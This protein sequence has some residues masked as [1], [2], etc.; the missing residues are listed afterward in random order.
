MPATRKFHP[1]S[2]TT[3]NDIKP[4]TKQPGGPA[5]TSDMG[6]AFSVRPAAKQL[7]DRTMLV[8][9]ELKVAPDPCNHIDS[10]CTMPPSELDDTVQQKLHPAAKQLDDR[11]PQSSCHDSLTEAHQWSSTSRSTAN[12]LD[13]QPTCKLQHGKPLL[14]IAPM[15]EVLE[16]QLIMGETSLPRQATKPLLTTNATKNSWYKRALT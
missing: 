1:G 15:C 12:Q 14:P 16:P 13:G 6:P 5:P 3:L 8:K 10:N 9:P 7:G 11:M 4:A 2:G